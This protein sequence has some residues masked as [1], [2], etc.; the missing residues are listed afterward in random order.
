MT[1]HLP[2]SLILAAL[3]L[4]ALGRAKGK[5]LTISCASN[6]KNWGYATAMYE[7]DF[8]DR[9]PLFGENS[10]DYTKPFWFQILAP[11]VAKKV[12]TAQIFVNDPGYWDALR[13]CPGGSTGHRRRASQ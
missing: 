13:R 7:G 8:S 2:Q 11:Y 3:L 10:G 1:N 9:F 12:L 4:P 5:A 6:M